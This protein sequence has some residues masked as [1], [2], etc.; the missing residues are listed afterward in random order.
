MIIVRL[1]GGL[2]NQM[3][4][5]AIGRILSIKNHTD[6][7][8]NIEIYKDKSERIFKKN[9]AVD[10]NH[11]L[12]VFNIQGRVA[13]KKEIPFIYRMYF[14]G[15]FM[16]LLDAIRR[17]V[18]RHNAQEIYFKKFNPEMLLLGSNVYIDGFFQSYKYFTGYEDIIRKDF[19]LKKEI[20]EYI[21][22]LQKEI[23]E[24][25]ALCVFVR[26]KDFVGNKYHEVVDKEY[27]SR[28]L[29]ILSKNNKIEKIYIFS[30]D[31]NWCKE[32]LKFDIDTM[33]VGDEYAGE[34]WEYHMFL[35]SNCKYFI[36]PNSTFAW[37]PAWLCDRY[38]K[39][40]IAPS[41]WVRDGSVNINDVIPND[42]IKI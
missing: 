38:D 14:K 16:V 6:L 40:V 26:R 39:K 34:K 33:F 5:Y 8:F 20:P 28:G 22:Y 12:E 3:F 15:K 2:G 7:L 4:Q 41:K 10:R 27:Y 25:E 32:N 31:L 36:I 21:K 23:S 37:W 13:T 1:K 11:D 17:R 9:F 29:S 24:K 42:W 18:L 19:V 35:M 30:D